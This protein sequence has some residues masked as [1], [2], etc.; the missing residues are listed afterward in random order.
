MPPSASS[1]SWRFRPC[2]KPNPKCLATALPLRPRQTRGNPLPTALTRQ[3]LRSW[4]PWRRTPSGFVGTP[5]TL[6]EN[7]G[8]KPPAPWNRWSSSFR[9]RRKRNTFAPA[10]LGRWAGSVPLPA[11]PCLR[12]SAPWPRRT[13]PCAAVPPGSLGQIGFATRDVQDAL[14][15]RLRDDDPLVRIEA[16]GSLFRLTRHPDAIATLARALVDPEGN[17]RSSS[18]SGRSTSMDRAGVNSAT[19]R[20]Q[21]A[22]ALG[23]LAAPAEA[24]VPALIR[25]LGSE[26]EDLRR[27]SARS[28]GQ[29]GPVAI[30]AVRPLLSD[31]KES[32]RAPP[33][34]RP[35][36]GSVPARPRSWP[37]QTGDRAPAVRRLA[38]RALGRLGPAAK[39]ATAALW[40]AVSD[41]D[42]SVRE[43]A[44]V[45]LRQMEASPSPAGATEEDNR[46]EVRDCFG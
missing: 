19:A 10:P 43:A 35:W 44:A 5:P 20:Y 14:E 36:N 18:L 42:A 13:P 28:L 26:D 9:A 46:E 31:S 3:W 25:S 32:V 39:Q 33:R 45:A 11:G 41:P 38:V 8:P 7:W 24:A 1:C 40:T 4:P 17:A 2:W 30:P 21:T 29:I 6:W 16:A 34:S 27:A 37:K 23:R 12:W 15:K 22:I